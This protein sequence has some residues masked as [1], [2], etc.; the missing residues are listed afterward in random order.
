M[1]LLKETTLPDEKTGVAIM[2]TVS[3]EKLQVSI[4][5]Y[6]A[7]NK[8]SYQPDEATVKYIHRVLDGV[9]GVDLSNLTLYRPVPS[10]E[11]PFGYHGRTAIMEQLN[12]T[13]DI[14]K[15]IRGDVA[16]INTDAI[17]KT[18]TAGGML[19]LEQKGVLAA[20]RGE[21]SIEE[22]GRVI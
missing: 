20:L 7:D 1:Q 8:E 9:S 18:A 16:D 4:E 14:Q 12:V 21:T 5:I 22:V 6:I 11:H 10:D 13:E 17:E 2:Q 3:R 19:T 15:F